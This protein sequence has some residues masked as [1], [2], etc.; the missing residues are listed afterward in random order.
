M[1]DLTKGVNEMNAEA[2]HTDSFQMEFQYEP[3]LLRNLKTAMSSDAMLEI[4]RCDW[5]YLKQ[6]SLTLQDCRVLRVYPRKGEYFLLEY[7]MCLLDD[8][9][10]R[11]ERVFGE[12]VGAEA[13]K[14]YEVLLKKLKETKRK[15][16]SRM[17]PT[18]RISCLPELG[19]IL[20]FSGID[21]KL[22]GMKL[23]NKPFLFKPI[24]EQCLSDK[25]EKISGCSIE[26]LRHRLRKR[27]I[28]R[29]RFNALNEKSGKTTRR[30][31][32]GKMY[33]DRRDRGEEVFTAMQGLW[34]NGFSDRSQDGIRIPKPIA[35]IPEFHLLLMEDVPGDYWLGLEHQGLEQAGVESSIK[36]AGKVLAKMHR[37]S[38]KVPKRHTVEDELKLLRE[39]WIVVASQI[40]PELSDSLKVAF[41]KVSHTLDKCRSFEPA[42]VHRDYYEKQVLVDG[43]KSFL[44]DFDTICLADPAID[45]GNF[46]AHIRLAGLQSPGCAKRLEEV[47]I[48][49]YA[50][51]R[52]GDFMTRVDAYTQ[53]TLLRLSCL[54][55]IWPQW[56]HLAQP[57]LDEMK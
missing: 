20:R 50:P 1:N 47:F 49:S 7:E 45:L 8:K 10:K 35:H 18:N 16:I 29:L 56:S 3:L 4:L 40:H 24:L 32:I 21:E 54:Y 30:S 57:L 11:V 5:P 2:P 15:Q 43:P 41:S 19:L 12:L 34:E 27:C 22:S 28:F 33:P 46:L 13:G 44:I 26:V 55:S 51:Q 6:E 52:S 42:L 23:I 38:L 9:G 48:K 25:R 37:S 31:L 14:Q 36:A 39:H 17:V 53:S